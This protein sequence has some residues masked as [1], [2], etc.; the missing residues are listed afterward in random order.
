MRK[1]LLSLAV[2]AGLFSS[3]GC[4]VY[5]PRPHPVAVYEV[6][7]GPGVVVYHEEYRGGYYYHRGYW[8]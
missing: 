4:V 2:F 8:R 3:T 1:M 6:Y 7:D 5:A